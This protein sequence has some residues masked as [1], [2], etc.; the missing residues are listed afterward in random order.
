M[1]DPHQTPRK[2]TLEDLLR[3]KRHERPGP[4]YW[5]RFDRELNERVWRA[6]VDPVGPVPKRTSWLASIMQ[7]RARWVTLGAVSLGA[8]AMTLSSYNPTAPVS[9]ILPSIAGQAT[10]PV[11]PEATVVAAVDDQPIRVAS[12]PAEPKGTPLPETA[13]TKYAETALDSTV[14]PSSSEKV[15]A[16]VSF[17]SEDAN[18]IRYASNSLTNGTFTTLGEESAY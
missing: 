1:P 12:I 9:T 2:I 6:L 3:L 11:N 5:A 15:P 17:I 14:N 18:G 16:T 7:G 8:V 4:E 10:P 13:E